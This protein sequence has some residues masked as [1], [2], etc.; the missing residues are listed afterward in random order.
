MTRIRNV[1]G[2]ITETT[3][4]NDVWYAKEDIVLNSLKTV[5]FKGDEK[6]VSYGKPE[7]PEITTE[8][9]TY[10]LESDYA[11][12]QLCNLA[13]ELGEMTFMVF[14]YKVFG[15][16]IEIQALSKL[17]R[18]LSD[19]KINNP[20]ILVSI[21]PV[22]GKLAGY[23]NKKKQI[24]VYE[25]FIE[26]ASKDNEKSAELLAALVEEYGHHIDN[27]LRTELSI[28]EVADE[29]VIDEGARFAYQL[30]KFDIFNEST[31]TF[32][33]AEIPSYKGDLKVD[34]SKL[35]NEIKK[36]VDE[37]NQYDEVPG[38]DI[39]NYGA[40]RNRK[41]NKNNAYAHGDIEFEA[42]RKK[43]LFSTQQVRNIYYGNWLRDFSQIIVGI[44]VRSTNVATEVQK[45][46]KVVREAAPL[47]FSHQ[48]LVSLMEI[49]AIKEF[50][51]EAE[52][53]NKKVPS[54]NYYIL[55]Q[56]F[57]KNFGGLTKDILGIYRPEEHIDNPKGLL[58]ESKITDDKGKVISF[59]YNGK[60]KTLYA[61]DNGISWKI[62][63]TR[64]MSNFFWINYPERPATVTYMKEQITLAC[65]EGQTVEGFR[66]LGAALH[67]LEDFFAHTNFV[68][69]LLRK[70]GADIYPWIEN[71]KGKNYTELP[72]VSGTFL[73]EDTIASVGPKIAELFFKPHIEEYKRR[74]P[75]E[76]TLGEMFVLQALQDLA[77]GQKS[78]TAKKSSAYY[79]V[80]VSTW[81]NWFETYLKFQDAMATMYE[82]ADKKEWG[83]TTFAEKVGVKVLE[84]TQ[85]S[86]DYSAQVMSI[87]PKLVFNIILNSFDEVIPEAQ[88]HINT[89]YGNCPSHS[90]LAKDSLTHPLN[91]L[92]AELAKIA[93]E[94]VG[95]KFKQGMD[96]SQLANYVAENYFVHPSS[97]KTMWTNKKI[98]DWLKGTSQSILEKLK[99]ATIYE[100]SHHEA[101]ILND[102][103]VKKI[104]EIMNYFK[105]NSQ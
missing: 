97:P 43:D 18:A 82:N 99:Y 68:E 105:E 6:G 95:R 40:G 13:D 61:G 63:K 86:M 1:G 39:S 12:N 2:K 25:K 30:F 62:D 41:E 32:A 36:I 98:N 8:K 37:T 87:F 17:Y 79:G 45:K 59:N 84:T 14:A 66:H 53:E 80:E 26:E 81:L 71:Y 85:K 76:R 46:Y 78:D 73:T 31:L 102:K 22:Q 58:D 47:K 89:K 7:S 103:T 11:H 64:N 90:Q 42:L 52:K 27:L 72:V 10:K 88:S 93:V 101:E 91:K 70:A 49:L 44:S 77:K 94:D 9:S 16:D 60:Q 20:E 3:K 96:G 4:G 19:R 33:K 54:E 34:F 104:K 57:N 92:S 21:Y 23:S 75:K 74:K 67:V 56:K 24:I 29:D 100:H 51:Y 28:N 65:S 15:S 38:E 35:Q 50:V 83:V 5:S 55:K 69:L 48:A